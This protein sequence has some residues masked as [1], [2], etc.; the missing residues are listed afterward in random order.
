MRYFVIVNPKSGQK[1]GRKILEKVT[2][3]LISAGATVD[4]GLS[5]YQGH[6]YKLANKFAIEEYDA[7]LVIGGDGT[8]HEVVNGIMDREIKRK[9]R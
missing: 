9:Y 4:N 2:P 3:L 5:E 6:P 7:L 1:K 8:M